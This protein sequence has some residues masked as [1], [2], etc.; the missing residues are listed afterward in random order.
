MSIASGETPLKL[1]TLEVL[2]L[3]RGS[4]SVAS[5][6]VTITA[7]SEIAFG[8]ETASLTASTSTDV[9]A[10][11]SLSFNVASPTGLTRRKQIVI[12]EDATITTATNVPIFAAVDTVPAGEVATYVQG[13]KIVAGLQE[14]SFQAQD[15]TVD[16]TD[17]LSGL[18]TEM[19]I[20]RS[21]LN[22]NISVIERIQN[23]GLSK[24]IKEVGLAFASKGR[25]V[26]ARLMYPD[27]ETHSGAAKVM[28]FSQPGNQNEVKKCSFELQFQGG[29]YVYTPAYTF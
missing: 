13:L 15:T 16:T 21:A 28:N 11:A 27:G 18:G 22:F 3:P 19:A 26:Y 24:I 8:A 25:E 23:E 14:F 20:V 7:A 1:V 2:L 12:R 6:T 9:K 5:N 17:T 29:S 4:R 10:G